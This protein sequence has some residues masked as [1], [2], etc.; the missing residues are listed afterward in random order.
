MVDMPQGWFHHKEKLL[1]IIKERT[2]VRCVE[3][4]SW[5]GLSA[6]SIA[7]LIRE[8]GGYLTCVD[9]WTGDVNGVWGREPGY[10]G[11]LA[12]C[13]F[14]LIQHGV[15]PNIR[16][17]PATTIAAARA[18]NE[19]IDLLYIDAD[20]SY[21]SALADLTEWWPHLEVG[22]IVAGDDY[23]N[24]DYPGV[25]QAFDEFERTHGQQFERH[26]TENTDPPGMKLVWGIKK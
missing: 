7:S 4:G 1:A 5:R 6:I 18:W 24:P 20:H 26:A 8:W 15:A 22:G 12:E 16:L 25:K 13:A 2:P 14:N 10:P 11:M 21:E 19:G 3:L 9:T 23:D 17:I